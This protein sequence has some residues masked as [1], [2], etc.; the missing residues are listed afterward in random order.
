MS[1]SI[2][3]PMIVV[4][5]ARRPS[6]LR[7]ARIITGLG[8]PTLKALT[9]VAASSMATIAP[10]P[11]RR[12]CLRRAIR[13]EVGGHQLG[14]VEDHPH[15]RFDHFE[16]ERAP[17]ADDDVIR[18][19]IHDRIAVGVQGVEQAALAD[20]V[21]GAARLL[22]GE[23]AG[24][25]HGAGEDVLLFDVDAQPAQLGRH[26]AARAL[27]VVGEKEEGNSRFRESRMKTSAPGISCRPR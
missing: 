1:V 16:V 12:P 14:A 20:D 19:V 11:G 17:F 3:S 10:Q 6:S 2:V 18:I 13:I 15:G 21:R 24:R 23:K 27:A 26:V 22:L 8:L 9:P 25:R 5:S 4:S 7:A